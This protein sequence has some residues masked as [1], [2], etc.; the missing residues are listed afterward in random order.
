MI[1]YFAG[2]HQED[3]EP[4]KWREQVFQ[5]NSFNY[6]ALFNDLQYPDSVHVEK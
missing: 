6:M 5:G 1:A 3:S 4:G 2:R